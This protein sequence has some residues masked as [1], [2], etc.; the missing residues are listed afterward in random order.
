MFYLF[1][2][3]TDAG[4]QLA[5]K[6]ESFRPSFPLVLG[7]PRGGVV[8]A[9]EAAQKLHAPLDVFIVRKLGVPGHA[10]LAMGALASGGLH[11]FNREIIRRL[12]IPKE[13]ILEVM[14]REQ[15][16]IKR[17]E[18]LYRRGAS[19]PALIH[20]RDVLLIDDGIATGATMQ[21]AVLALKQ[22][23]PLSLTVAVPV[24]SSDTC[25]EL[26]SKADEII[27]LYTPVHFSSVGE[28]Y[29]NFEQTTDEEV[30]ALLSQSQRI[31]VPS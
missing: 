2:D 15:K 1:K 12:K 9:F 24:A 13:A 19:I 11:V 26:A 3:R 27:C 20:G 8:V 4:R 17:R 21:S 22:A 7:L 31:R 25:R 23:R 28:W 30:K 16:E 14:D 18:T 6:L 29:E 10:E 5:E